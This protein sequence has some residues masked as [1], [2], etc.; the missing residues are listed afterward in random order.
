MLSNK[1][2]WEFYSPLYVLQRSEGVILQEY[3]WKDF[4]QHFFV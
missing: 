2:S 4:L 1:Q 3:L